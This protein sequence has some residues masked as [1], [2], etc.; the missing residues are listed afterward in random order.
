MQLD[1]VDSEIHINNYVH[2]YLEVIFIYKI[3]VIKVQLNEF[4]LK[5]YCFIKKKKNLESPRI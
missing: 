5:N 4:T 3:C 1:S 2:T